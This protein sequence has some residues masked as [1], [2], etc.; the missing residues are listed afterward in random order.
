MLDNWKKW[1]WQ[2][3]KN[4]FSQGFIFEDFQAAL[5]FINKVGI[6]SERLQHHPRINGSD[7]SALQASGTSNAGSSTGLGDGLEHQDPSHGATTG[8][9]D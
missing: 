1:G 7:Q 5:S 3:S 4:R 2:F 6:L 9:E 8:N